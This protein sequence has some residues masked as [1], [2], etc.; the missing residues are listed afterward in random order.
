MLPLLLLL[1]S[2]IA[3][4]VPQSCF[5]VNGP[6]GGSTGYKYLS[7]LNT[8]MNG[9]TSTMRPLSLNICSTSVTVNKISIKTFSALQMTLADSN[10]NPYTLDMIG[11]STVGQCGSMDFAKGEYITSITQQYSNNIT[12]FIT[13]TTSTGSALNIGS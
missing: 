7:E 1:A 3:A 13:I 8:L 10:G 11:N 5:S 9:M 4:P 12:T 6:F 2:T